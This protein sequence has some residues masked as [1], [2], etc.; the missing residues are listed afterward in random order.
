MNIPKVIIQTSKLR[1]PKYIIEL[2]KSKSEG[3][4]YKHFTDEDI[5]EF[6]DNNPIEEFPKCPEIFHSFKM[7]QHK[8]DF[9]RYYYLYIKG[10]V[11]VDSDLIID[12]NIDTIIENYSF[13]TVESMFKNSMFNG[14]IGSAPK[15]IILYQALKDAYFIDKEKLNN[16]Y[17]LICKNLYNIVDNYIKLKDHFITDKTINTK[18]DHKILTEEKL[19]SDIAVSK[20][21][22]TIV[23]SHYYSKKINIESLV[24][25]KEKKIKSVSKTKIGITFHLPDSLF[26]NGNN[27]NA[28]YFGEL[29]LNIGYDCYFII[30]KMEKV[31]DQVRKNFFYSDKFKLAKYNEIFYDDYDIIFT[32]GFDIPIENVKILKYMKTKIVKYLCGNKYFMDSEKILYDQHKSSKDI[33]Y[34]RKSELKDN[35]KLYDQLWIIPQMIN[36]NKY[37]YQ[38]LYRSES[39]EVPFIW[40]DS[41]IKLS[42]LTE[43]I[44]NENELLYKV[45]N[46][47]NKKIA[48]FEPNISMM[49]WCLPA[50]LVCENYYR[51]NKNIGN[52]YLTNALNMGNN[53]NT[54]NIDGLNSIVKNLDLFDDKKISIES[55]HVTLIFMKKHADIA[56]SHQMEN[57]LNYL[58]F[59]LAWMGWPIIHNA[60]LCRDIGYYYDGFNYEM[61]GKALSDA[62]LNHDSNIDNYIKSNRK[63][64]DKY[65]P[66]NKELQN[67]YKIL[68]E[69]LFVESKN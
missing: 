66:R 60:H 50:L 65:L 54:F 48:V 32:F 10:G 36:T 19:N 61:G 45:K 51:E 69:N 11:Y 9:F 34:I 5:I 37:Y 6:M 13:I 38:L 24:P 25:I 4:E 41:S 28:L 35:Q 15:H 18:P 43:N 67:K 46:K 49:K 21:G 64:M 33:N 12:V 59:D 26:S 63:N 20:D 17:F 40:S 47:E 23:L 56:V 52:V 39:I 31:N 22:D 44:E 7:G 53:I 16:D 68:I 1:P 2:I 62:I 58:Y 57:P 8:A 42:C 3:W 27:Q 30:E 29:L 14:F 55:R